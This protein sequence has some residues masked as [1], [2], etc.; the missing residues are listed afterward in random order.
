MR[1]KLMTGSLFVLLIIY[2]YIFIWYILFCSLGSLI[3]FNSNFNFLEWILDLHAH[4]LGHW[5]DN[6]DLIYGLG[7]KLK[8][9]CPDL[10]IFGNGF[11]PRCF[12]VLRIFH[13]GHEYHSP[14]YG[15]PCRSM[16]PYLRRQNIDRKWHET[17]LST[18]QSGTHH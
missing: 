10:L 13:P 11:N 12:H 18:H 17:H 16:A 2:H 3:K 9:K 8:G 4:K 5:S 7:L 1:S 6:T 14:H 15:G